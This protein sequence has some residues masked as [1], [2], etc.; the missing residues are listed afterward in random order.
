[1]AQVTAEHPAL[2]DANALA[3]VTEIDSLIAANIDA[4]NRAIVDPVGS[5]KILHDNQERIF[6]IVQNDPTLAALSAADHGFQPLPAALQPESHH[7][8]PIAA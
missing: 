7:A 2:F 6:G 8:S 4:V 1:M 5:A 3:H